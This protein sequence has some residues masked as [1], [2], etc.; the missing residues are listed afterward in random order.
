MAP[1]A[2]VIVRSRLPG[3]VIHLAPSPADLELK[4]GW[5]LRVEREHPVVGV[6]PQSLCYAQ[7]GSHRPIERQPDVVQGRNLEHEVVNAFPLSASESHRVV[8]RAPVHEGNVDGVAVHRADDPI[9]QVEP[10]QIAVKA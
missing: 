5:R 8:A 1:L 3:R 4:A 2:D 6:S 9:G 7:T 10:Q